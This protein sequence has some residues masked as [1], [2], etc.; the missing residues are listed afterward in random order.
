VLSHFSDHLMYGGNLLG[1]AS[2]D[3]LWDTIFKQE[4][5]TRKT[6][7]IPASP[8]LRLTCPKLTQEST[9]LI[10]PPGFYSVLLRSDVPVNLLTVM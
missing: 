5:K 9:Q 3:S 6:H 2:L 8:P 7:L 10:L 1:L 4:K